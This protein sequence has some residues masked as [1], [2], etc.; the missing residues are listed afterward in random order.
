ML[1][2]ASLVIAAGGYPLVEAERAAGRAL[3]SVLVPPGVDT[4]RFHPLDDDER[5]AARARLGLPT[6]GR[7]VVSLSRLVPRKGFDV[8]ITPRPSSHRSAPTSSSPSAAPA[9]TTTALSAS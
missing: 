6:D 2:G 8:L 1:R 3:P 7:L 5:A 4:D 9:A